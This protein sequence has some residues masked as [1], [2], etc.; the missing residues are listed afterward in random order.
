MPDLILPFPPS[1]NAY[2]ENAQRRVRNSNRTYT[3]RMISEEG[4]RFRYGVLYACRTQQFRI[5]TGRLTMEIIAQE[6][7][8]SRA[9]D[10]DNLLKA[11][12]D[13]LTHAGAIKDD[14][15]FDRVV[16]ERGDCWPHDGGRLLV[17]I[18][19]FVAPA[20]AGGLFCDRKT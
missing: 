17:S 18:K 20:M 5:Q 13:A 2:Y 12:Q 7:D 6:P 1:L 8:R 14:C 4:K 9:R 15:F 10:L 19:P 16:V 3:A 11:T